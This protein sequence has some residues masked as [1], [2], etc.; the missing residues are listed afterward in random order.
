[1]I[2][3][4]SCFVPHSN[5]DVQ[6][7]LNLLLSRGYPFLRTCNDGESWIGSKDWGLP[8]DELL[9]GGFFRGNIQLNDVASE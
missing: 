5:N 4:P 6:V 9:S 2:A 7:K 1:M 3:D 8:I